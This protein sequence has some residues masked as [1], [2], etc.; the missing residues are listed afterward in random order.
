MRVPRNPPALAVGRKSTRADARPSRKDPTVNDDPKAIYDPAR[1]AQ[2]TRLCDQHLRCIDA[3]RAADMTGTELFQRAAGSAKVKQLFSALIDDDSNPPEMID[4]PAS[5]SDADRKALAKIGAHNRRTLHD[6]AIGEIVDLHD[7]IDEALA[8]A[9]AP[10][11]LKLDAE[12]ARIKIDR[13]RAR[14]G[15]TA[16][17]AI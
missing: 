16:A 15:G 3:L 6:V 13:G 12:F 10:A 7:E 2:T 8:R 11:K 4:A 1:T 14:Q 5:L 17:G 9:G